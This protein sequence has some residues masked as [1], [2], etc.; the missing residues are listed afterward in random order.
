MTDRF[1]GAAS[2]PRANACTQIYFFVDF[3]LN[4][5]P[6]CIAIFAMASGERPIVLTASFNDFEAR[7][8]SI[9]CRCSLNDQL[10]F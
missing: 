1:R 8:N 3:G 2:P 6:S 7:A 5:I 4:E 10:F 9:N